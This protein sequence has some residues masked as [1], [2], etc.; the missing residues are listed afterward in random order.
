VI[1]DWGRESAISGQRLAVRA[2]PWRYE[3]E[4]VEGR[5][6]V[7]IHLSGWWR[8]GYALARCAFRTRYVAPL[9]L[10]IDAGA[11]PAASAL[12]GERIALTRAVES[13]R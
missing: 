4:R 3:R 12:L 5:G 6:C 11:A 7:W 2:G 8:C 9:Q 13:S 10:R 1:V